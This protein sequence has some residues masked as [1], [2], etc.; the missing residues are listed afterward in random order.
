M[1]FPKSGQLPLQ[2]MIFILF[3][4][5]KSQ[6]QRVYDGFQKREVQNTFF[7]CLQTFLNFLDRINLYFIDPIPL[8]PQKN[9]RIVWY[10]DLGLYILLLA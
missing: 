3:F 4:K 6:E 1:A 5:R 7:R 10:Q 9:C 2:G 8:M